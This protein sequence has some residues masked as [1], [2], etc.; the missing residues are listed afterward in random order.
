MNA[1]DIQGDVLMFYRQVSISVKAGRPLSVLRTSSKL[2]GYWRILFVILAPPAPCFLCLQRSLFFL[3]PHSSLQK[4]A[5][6]DLW[7][8]NFSQIFYPACSLQHNAHY[9]AEWVFV[10]VWAQSVPRALRNFN[11]FFQPPHTQHRFVES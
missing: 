9:R 5:A 2:L 11:P 10:G 4:T 8:N 7:K 1:R 3:L 6:G